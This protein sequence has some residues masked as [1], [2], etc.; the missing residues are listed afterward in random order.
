[1]LRTFKRL[2]SALFTATICFKGDVGSGKT[3]VACL[4]GLSCLD[5][6]FGKV[7]V[8]L[9]PTTILAEQHVNNLSRIAKSINEI[10][11]NVG[12]GKKVNVCSYTGSMKS[13][14]REKLLRHI[15]MSKDDGE[16]FFLVG[17]HALL[18]S[19]VAERLSSNVGIALSVIDEEQR[20]GVNQR[21]ILSDVSRCILYMTAT[22]IPRTVALR[23]SNVSSPTLVGAIDVSTIDYKPENARHVTTKIIDESKLEDLMYGVKKQVEIG[24]KIIWILPRIGEENNNESDIIDDEVNDVSCV[25]NRH[26]ALSD[27][28]GESCVSYV[29]GQLSEDE[30]MQRISEFS[31]PDSGVNVIVGTTVLE[32]GID[33]PLVTILIVEK[34]ERFGLSQLHQLRGRVGRPLPNGMKEHDKLKCHFALI[35]SCDTS[36]DKPSSQRLKILATTT[37]SNK[38]AEEDFRIRGQGDLFGTLQA[39]TTK[40]SCIDVNA[41]F[42]M[43]QAASW[44]GR[45]IFREGASKKLNDAHRIDRS[46]HQSNQLILDYYNKHK[47]SPYFTNAMETT[48]ISGFTLRVLMCIYENPYESII[49]KEKSLSLNKMINTLSEI[50]AETSSDN[51]ED[52]QNLFTGL[53]GDEL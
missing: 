16:V 10:S 43:I 14:E 12:L 25:I 39:G 31:D 19:E 53:L 9:S 52:T 4:A 32:V 5:A 30:R 42:G 48:S 7:V 50:N 24:A 17:T 33:I 40:S 6:K 38:I 36:T 27:L 51:A 46:D 47:L 18:S 45:S 8:M 1:M 35:T 11:L 26:L 2:D 44:M 28:L 49:T 34:A 22:P 21:T 15:E 23:G 41:H 29:H 37:D 13:N 3:A 20:F